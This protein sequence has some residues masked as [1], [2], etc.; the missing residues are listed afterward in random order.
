MRQDVQSAQ[1]VLGRARVRGKARQDGA[2]SGSGL[3]GFNSGVGHQANAKRGVLHAFRRPFPFSVQGAKNRR[4]VFER[5]AH[6]G[7]VC[8]GVGTGGGEDVREVAGIGG[9]Q[10]EGGKSVR[11]NIG[12]S[13]EVFS[14]R[15]GKT[16]DALNAVHHV[17]SL[18]AGHRHIGE[19]FSGFGRCE[20]GGRAHLLGLVG[21][22]AH[23]RRRRPADGLHLAHRG[24]ERGERVDGVF[25][26][27]T[28]AQNGPR[29]KYRVF[30]DVQDTPHGRGD[31]IHHAHRDI[32]RFS[33][34]AVDAGGHFVDGCRRLVNRLKADCPFPARELVQP[35]L[36][37]LHGLLESAQTGTG[38]FCPGFGVVRRVDVDF[39]PESILRHSS[40]P[41]FTRSPKFL[42]LLQPDE[43]RGEHQHSYPSRLAH[44]LIRGNP[45]PLEY[46]VQQG[47]DS[48]GFNQFFAVSTS[49]SASSSVKPLISS[50]LS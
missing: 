8:V 10:A 49:L 37:F 1:T 20:F 38:G 14:R 44:D 42:F 12:R 32:P 22:Q 43:R 6:H 27:E 40:S 17:F 18:P 35:V 31:F 9:G 50:I 7:Y 36:R 26:A 47:C 46:L 5:L 39:N 34:K 25:Q 23:F 19:G 33:G 48:P 24:L 45:L 2:Q 29:L 21:Q 13:C 15:G 28:D 11:H 30:Q 4:D 3:R 16:H 41:A